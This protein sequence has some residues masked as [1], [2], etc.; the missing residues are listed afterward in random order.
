MN[1]D[2]SAKCVMCDSD[3]PEEAYLKEDIL[4]KIEPEAKPQLVEKI[5]SEVDLKKLEEQ[6][7]L[8]EEA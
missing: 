6:K 4:E 8:E 2:S 5:S 1:E 7:K 3:P